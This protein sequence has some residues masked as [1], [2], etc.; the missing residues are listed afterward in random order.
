MKKIFN[1]LF[2]VS[3]VLV[4]ASG[5]MA[6]T[7]FTDTTEVQ[8]WN[9]LSPYGSGVWTDVI[10]DV[11]TFDTF[12][13]NLSGNILTIYTNWN[14]DKTNLNFYGAVITTADLFISSGSL[15]YAIQLGS[16]TGTGN[17]YT[18]PSIIKTSVDYIGSFGSL[19]YGGKYDSADPKS[20]PVQAIGG[21]IGSTDVVWTY[22]TS[23]L[24]NQVAIDLSGLNLGSEWSF[25]WGTAT[26]SN[27][28]ISGTAPVPLP[29]SVLLLGAGLM[30]MG[31]RRFRKS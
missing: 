17:V 29:P 25:V 8:Q 14:P 13:A 26:C 30:G 1:T 16:L 15:D 5:V 28:A 7:Y 6:D 19:V 10:G 24:N 23:G 4:S 31:W 12:G 21:T 3:L 2:I 9:G 22:G 27:D 20:T 11:N 18:E